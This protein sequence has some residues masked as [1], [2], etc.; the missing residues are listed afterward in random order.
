MA[1]KHREQFAYRRRKPTAISSL[2]SPPLPP[3]ALVSRRMELN[4]P[5]NACSGLNVSGVVPMEI[6]PAIDHPNYSTAEAFAR[7]NAW[8]QGEADHGREKIM[9]AFIDYLGVGAT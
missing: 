5:I 2:D 9:I 8:P 4:I 1:R 7:S 6:E 3:H